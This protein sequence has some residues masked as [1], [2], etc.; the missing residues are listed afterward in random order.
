MAT[1]KILFVLSLS[2]LINP[3]LHCMEDT[4]DEYMSTTKYVL[5]GLGLAG[6]A[7]FFSVLGARTLKRKKQ[8]LLHGS[9]NIK[10]LTSEKSTESYVILKVAGE[11]LGIFGIFKD[12]SDETLKKFHSML[13]TKLFPRNRD[14]LF[15]CKYNLDGLKVFDHMKIMNLDG[16][17][18]I[19]APPDNQGKRKILIVSVSDYYRA[20]NIVNKTATMLTMNTYNHTVDKGH[21]AL[22]ATNYATSICWNQ[23]VQQNQSLVEVMDSK[24]I[25][26]R[27]LHIKGNNQDFE[28]KLIKATRDG[29][30]QYQEPIVKDIFELSKKN[31]NRAVLMIP[32]QRFYKDVPFFEKK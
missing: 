20:Y 30:K 13:V 14:L 16:I 27:G 17:V 24:R 25:W 12:S 28:K 26:F 10:V 9:Q 7:V 32:V 19:M 21:I 2:L 6:A 5:G 29:L 31:K 22:D 1:R 8:K 3:A 15:N 23:V 18:T 4:D 11:S